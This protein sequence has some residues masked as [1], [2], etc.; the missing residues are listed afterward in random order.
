MVLWKPFSLLLLHGYPRR[1][2]LTKLV[3][4]MSR[5][6][7]LH[8]QVCPR[9]RISITMEVQRRNFLNLRAQCDKVYDVIEMV[10]YLIVLRTTR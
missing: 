6:T 2:S 7:V 8:E 4:S 5:F 1:I 10:S 3:L 9:L